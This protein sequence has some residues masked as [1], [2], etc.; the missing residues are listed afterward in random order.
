MVLGGLAGPGGTWALPG[1]A[2]LR[3][4]PAA[5]ELSLDDGQGSSVTFSPAGCR[6][7]V[8]SAVTVEAGQLHVSAGMVEIDSGMVRASGVVRAST[9]ITDTIVAATYTP[10][11][12]NVW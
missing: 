7:T 10:G 3:L 6:L 9:V 8:P 2:R 12:G 1:G 11:A 4:D 5:H